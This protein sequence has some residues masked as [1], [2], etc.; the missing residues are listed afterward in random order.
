MIGSPPRDCRCPDNTRWNPQFR[1]CDPVTTTPPAE[2]GIFGAIAYSRATKAFGYA[3]NMPSREAAAERAVQQ[4][5]SPGCE[6][7]QRFR[8]ACAALAIG[9]N[10]FGAAWAFNQRAAAIRAGEICDRYSAGCSIKV[11]VCSGH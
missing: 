8:N 9:R 11:S 6:V 7:V 5:G 3:I 10:G 1:R 2:T 4:C